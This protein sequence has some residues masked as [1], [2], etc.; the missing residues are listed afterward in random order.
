MKTNVLVIVVDALRFDRVGAFGGRELTPHIDNLASNAAVF[1]DAYSTTN[2]TDPAITSIQT[3][4]YPL[5]HGVINHGTRVTDEEKHTV[6]QITQLPEVLSDAGYSTAKFG[7]PLGRWHRK[8]FDRYPS[9]METEEAFDEQDDTTPLRHRVGDALKRIHPRF[10][11]AASELYQATKLVLQNAPEKGDV[12][13]NYRNRTDDV[14]RNFETF[15]RDSTPFYSFVHLMDTHTPY[16]ANPE[17]VNSYLDEFDY[18]TDVSMRGTGRHPAS[19]DQLVLGGEYPELREQYYLS[20]GTPTT[21]IT[22]AHY[23]ATVT[24]ADER[25]GTILDV[26]KETGVFDDTLIVFVAD[27]GESLTEH[28]I[29]HDHHGLYDV[30]THVPLIVR[31]PGGASR[32]VSEFVQITDIAPTVESYTGTDGVD[33]DGYSLRPVIEDGESLDRRYILAEEAHT[34]RRRMVRSH[35]SKLIYLLDGDTICRYCGVQHAPEIEFYDLETDPHERENI[36]ESREDAVVELQ[37]YGE[38]TADAFTQRKPQVAGDTDVEYEDEDE[39]EER[40]EA[41]GYR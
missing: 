16:T 14:V 5:S 19:F 25:V 21:A 10:S 20:D 3:G 35:D 4:R 17:L 26:L 11:T 41:L 12:I 6:E 13:A 15:V 18:Q 33:A 24:Q 32:E 36:A 9:S 38:R 22:D 8:G 29:Y 39:V 23:D 1:T 28:G 27:H 7:R 2:V 30:S 31:P 34:Q 40:L 37:E